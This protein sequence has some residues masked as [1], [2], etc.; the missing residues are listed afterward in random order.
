MKQYPNLDYL[1]AET[2]VKMH[3]QG[4]L[5]Q[6]DFEKRTTPP[7]EHTGCITI[8]NISAEVKCEAPKVA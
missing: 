8:E 2:L 1:M 3:E 5:E 4:K 7:P 6:F